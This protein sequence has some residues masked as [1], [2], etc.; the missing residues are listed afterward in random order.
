[1]SPADLL[2]AIVTGLLVVTVHTLLL[3]PRTPLGRMYRKEGQE[4][5]SSIFQA[6]LYFL[7][8]LLGILCS[9]F[10]PEIRTFLG[11]G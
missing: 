2:V 9:I 5:G 7:Y 11:L 4:G 6:I 1:M 10:A 3:A 8:F